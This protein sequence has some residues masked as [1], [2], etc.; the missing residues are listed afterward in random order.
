MLVRRQ[1]ECSSSER[2]LTLVS[3]RHT[4]EVRH[5]YRCHELNVDPSS[6]EENTHAIQLVERYAPQASLVNS[7]VATVTGATKPRTF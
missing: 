1:A 5:G 4:L 7:A 3:R 2:L 6:P